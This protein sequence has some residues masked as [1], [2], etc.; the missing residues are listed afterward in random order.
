MTTPSGSKR[1]LG[2]ISTALKNRVWCNPGKGTPSA[3]RIALA[4]LT[5]VRKA[6]VDMEDILKNEPHLTRNRTSLKSKLSRIVENQA[7]FNPKPDKAGITNVS[8]QNR[9]FL[10]LNISQQRVE[11]VRVSVGIFFPI[12]SSSATLFLPFNRLLEKGLKHLLLCFPLPLY[13]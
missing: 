7:A 6:T 5:I 4:P 2:V 1:A 11:I 10:M 9:L 12:L 13:V 8:V 3:P